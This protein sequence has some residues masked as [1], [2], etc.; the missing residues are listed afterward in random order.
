MHPLLARLLRKVGASPG[1]A[2]SAEAWRGLLELVDRTYVEADQDR[3]TLERSI[4]ISSR[5]MQG[6]YETL[7]RRAQSELD[8]ERARV[9]DRDAIIGAT[10]DAA[11]EGIVVVDRS[12]RVLAANRRFGE[13]IGASRE[14][15]ESSDYT[16]LVASCVQA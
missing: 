16:A 7:K 12:R 8:R 11:S 2:P 4:E 9:V 13:M 3:Y 6:L 14:L 10:L 5:E 15:L 1:E